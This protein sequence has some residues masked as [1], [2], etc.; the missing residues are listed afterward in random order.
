MVAQ[1]LLHNDWHSTEVL[2]V[3]EAVNAGQKLDLVRYIR[4]LITLVR[5]IGK[6]AQSVQDAAV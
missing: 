4:E 1:C 3:D 6:R 5:R 2:C